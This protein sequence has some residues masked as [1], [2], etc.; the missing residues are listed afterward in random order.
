[1]PINYLDQNQQRIYN[2]KAINLN[3]WAR[4]VSNMTDFVIPE[5]YPL[6]R[7]AKKYDRFTG[8]VRC[9]VEEL[10]ATDVEEG[11]GILESNQTIY[12][13]STER[14][15]L[16]LDWWNVARQVGA[17]KNVE[18][19]LPRFYDATEETKQHVY[20]TFLPA[21]RAIKE[22]FQKRSIF[23]YIFNHSQ[24]VAERDSLRALEGVIAT[25]TGD[26]KEAIGARL[27]AYVAE[28]PSSDLAVS[29][30]ALQERIQ[31]QINEK[32]ESVLLEDGS[33]ELDEVVST[34]QELGVSEELNNVSEELGVPEETQKTVRGYN[35][36]MLYEARNDE[37]FEERFI[38]QMKEAMKKECHYLP[39]DKQIMMIKLIA[40][41]RLNDTA[42][43]NFN[44]EMDE[45]IENGEQDLNAVALKGIK[46]VYEQAYTCTRLLSIAS[47]KDRLIVA[48]R[49]SDIVLNT[50]TP[51]AFQ[52]ERF[53]PYG[54][55]YMLMNTNADMIKDVVKEQ[56]TA[57]E[58]FSDDEIEAAFHQAQTEFNLEMQRTPISLDELD[59][60]GKDNVVEPH[61]AEKRIDPPVNAK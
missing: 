33:I 26:G 57:K 12:L 58:S 54:K 35:R 1:M 38:S 37:K 15:E 28:I 46:S 29:A 24:Y 50:V 8:F 20:D 55:G 13:L 41:N 53:G 25:L 31:R 2:Q 51:I 14:S 56:F 59:E 43:E 18:N 48:Q 9:W 30:R 4:R 60:R 42:A 21:Y 61:E 6:Q 36:E 40:N 16:M 32:N 39:E 47:L 10:L 23:Q 52:K 34:E 44:N 27:D 7:G 3:N 17:G 19:T 45:A 11:A 49:F 22:S 5:Q